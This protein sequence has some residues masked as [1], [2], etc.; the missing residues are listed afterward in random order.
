MKARDRSAYP[1][2]FT[3]V[4]LM[5]VVAVVAVL[6][7]MAAPNLGS[8]QR[9][10]ELRATSASFL[11]ALQTARTEAVK[12]GVNVYMVPATADDW[13][14]GWVVFAD[15]NWDQVFTRGTDPVLVEMG[16]LPAK[17]RVAGG[18]AEAAQFSDGTSRYI[19][20]NGSGFPQSKTNIPISGAIE[21]GVAGSAEP[22]RRVVLNIVGRV[23]V[24]DPARDTSSDCKQ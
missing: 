5:V 24:C 6:L 7:G 16:R 15:T 14:T 10:S 17:T 8:F 13:S 23:R 22:R 12:R 18:V 2:G 21:F 11:A 19:R 1:R 9:S 3:L 20:F 4:E